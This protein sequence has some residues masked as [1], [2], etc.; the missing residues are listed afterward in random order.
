MIVVRTALTLF[1]RFELPDF[2]GFR[3]ERDL[4]QARSRGGGI[5]APGHRKHDALGGTV[6]QQYIA[7]AVVAAS[8]GSSCAAESGVGQRDISQTSA[9]IKKNVST[10][11]CLHAVAAG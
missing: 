9:S 10:A 8:K 1:A 7:T 4:R 2:D 5:E 3:E 11:Q 6:N